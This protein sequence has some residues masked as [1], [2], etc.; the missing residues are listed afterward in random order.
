MS[1]IG[2]RW[3]KTVRSRPFDQNSAFN[4][5]RTPNRAWQDRMTAETTINYEALH[6]TAMRGLVRTVLVGVAKSGLPGD[7]HL[8]ISFDVRA[9]GVVL[10]KRLREKY[11]S[12]MTIVLQH[13]FWD[14]LVSE[15]RF[16]V[17]LTFD[18]IP[19]RLVV[20][21]TAIKVFLDPSVRFV[22]HF[23]DPNAPEPDSVSLSD[24]A[25]TAGAANTARPSPIKKSRPPRARKD[26]AQLTSVARSAP[27]PIKSGPSATKSDPPPPAPV[28][29]APPPA[30][31]APNGAAPAPVP[32]P[33]GGAQ[34]VSLDAFRKK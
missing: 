1:A 3:I 14:L 13:R 6:Q 16:E 15:E 32:T 24:D 9:P 27:T 34:V 19:E 5:A 22:M 23:E 21:F 31:P 18:G 29:V 25:E 11:P 8:Y 10:S 4:K 26:G 12:E 33:G 2:L 20:P 30:E 28:P 7:H 17:K